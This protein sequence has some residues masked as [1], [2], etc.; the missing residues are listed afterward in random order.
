MQKRILSFILIMTLLININVM[1]VSAASTEAPN[2]ELSGILEEPGTGVEYILYNPDITTS[3]NGKPIIFVFHGIESSESEL[4]AGGGLAAYQLI[5]RNVIK[6]NALIVF[7]RKDY[8]NWADNSEHSLKSQIYATFIHN[9]LASTGADTSR[10]YYYGF[11]MGAWD[12]PAI[13]KA[14]GEGTFKAAVFNDGNPFSCITDGELEQYVLDNDRAESDNNMANQ[15]MSPINGNRG[16]IFIGESH[17]HKLEEGMT[18]NDI[19]WEQPSTYLSNTITTKKL[20]KQ[21]ASEQNTI[22]SVVI[23]TTTYGLTAENVTVKTNNICSEYKIAWISDLH[24]MLPHQTFNQAWYDRQGMTPADR[25][26]VF[27]NS[28]NIMEN[29]VNCINNNNFDAVV[30]GGDII[31]NYSQENYRYLQNYINQINKKVIFLAADHDYLTEMTTNTGINKETINL[32]G[33]GSSNIKQVNIGK[34]GDN[35]TLIA[36]SCS[37]EPISSP[38]LSTVKNL[39]NSNTNT[40]FFTHVPLEPQSNGA[41][42]QQWSKDVHNNQVYYWSPNAYKANYVPK[43]N[44][45]ELINTLYTSSSLKGVFTGHMHASYT[46]DFSTSAI[47]HVFDG[48]FRNKIGVITVTPDIN[49]TPNNEL[50]GETINTYTYDYGNNGNGNNGNM[51]FIHTLSAIGATE[52]EHGTPG[53]GTQQAFPEWLYDGDG[54]TNGIRTY[55]GTAT[56]FERAKKII[57]NNPDIDSWIVVVM[58]GYFTPGLGVGAWDKYIS[59]LNS[60]KSALSQLGCTNFYVSSSPHTNADI[61]EQETCYAY[62]NN[63]VIR[64]LQGADSN[65]SNANIDQYNGY[66]SERIQNYINVTDSSGNNPL[67]KDGNAY[68]KYKTI[69]MIDSSFCFDRYAHIDMNHYDASTMYAWAEYVLNYID[70]QI[71]ANDGNNINGNNGANQYKNTHNWLGLE[72]IYLI[73]G[74][75]NHYDAN[76]GVNT[77]RGRN[78]LFLESYAGNLKVED[79]SGKTQDWINGFSV[80]VKNGDAAVPPWNCMEVGDA[81][82]WLL[83]Q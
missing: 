17:V 80:A 24:M 31:D 13:I 10:V 50:I 22:Q 65:T 47:E 29:I 67:G 43:D 82:N 44:Q 21:N 34:N 26:A 62:A 33:M 42:M 52:P 72:G 19:A 69:G 16:V 55:Q 61:W 8:G 68:R 27:L 35:L 40:L 70:A 46:T 5:S 37:N 60:M 48:A 25:I 57:S 78:A 39:L 18:S 59:N 81:Y 9:V 3:T 63:T 11:S 30:F 74:S 56:A 53:Q 49:N 64:N 7:V 71:G 36:Q 2:P 76:A 14:C 1:G 12:G 79:Y 41:S 45:Q 28:H 15:N 20:K 32:G 51:F 23:D 38:D 66:V 54:T 77:E 83:R 58:Q 4:D 75:E 73:E 6:P